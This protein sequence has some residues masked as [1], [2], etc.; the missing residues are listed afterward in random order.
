MFL[1]ADTKLPACLGRLQ[2]VLWSLLHLLP[3]VLR[4]GSTTSPCAS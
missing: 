2:S 1:A 4:I 3:D